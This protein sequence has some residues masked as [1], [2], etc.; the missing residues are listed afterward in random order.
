[1]K[2]IYDFFK[3]GQY[4]EEDL[5]IRRYLGSYIL[6]YNGDDPFYV[7]YREEGIK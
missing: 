5:R 2:S 4:E 3:H 6:E 1:M 7:L